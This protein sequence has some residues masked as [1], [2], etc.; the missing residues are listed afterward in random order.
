MVGKGILTSFQPRCCCIT[1]TA[2]NAVST[3]QETTAS[4]VH[5]CRGPTGIGEELGGSRANMKVLP[6]KKMTLITLCILVRECFLVPGALAIPISNLLTQIQ[7]AAMYGSCLPCGGPRCPLDGQ[8]WPPHI[9]HQVQPKL[10]MLVEEHI[11][12]TI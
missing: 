4:R 1:A 11:A 2:Q 3:L 12:T 5:W 9:G 10:P 7:L 6:R 8:R